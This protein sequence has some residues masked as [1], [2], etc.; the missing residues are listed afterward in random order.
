MQPRRLLILGATEGIAA[1]IGARLIAE[2][3]CVAADDAADAVLVDGTDTGDEI[4]FLELDDA[5]FSAQVID[6]T[7]DRVAM[8]HSALPRLGAAASIVVVG[9]DAYLGRWHGTGQAAASAALLGIMRSV[10]MEYARYAVRANM[11][12]LPL[13][14]NADDSGTIGDAARQAAAL[15][16]AV[17]I[18]GETVLIDGGNSLKMR[19]AKR[20]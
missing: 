2:G 3:T 18:T 19:Q 20:R 14:T 9:S 8:L 1:A 5:A 11:I 12:A 13:G 6:A 17:S 15:F 16:D 10:G 4:P 7:L